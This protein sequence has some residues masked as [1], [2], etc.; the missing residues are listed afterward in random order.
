MKIRSK[1]LPYLLYILLATLISF[2]W[3]FPEHAI[4]DIVADQIRQVR[5][6]LTIHITRIRPVMPPGLKLSDVQVTTADGLPVDMDQVWLYPKWSSLLRFKPAVKFRMTLYEG[7]LNGVASRANRQMAVDADFAD[8]Q[9]KALPLVDLLP[10]DITIDP[11]QPGYI[12]GTVS[13]RSGPNN[14]PQAEARIQINDVRFEL[15]TDLIALEPIKISQMN[16]HLAL[17]TQRW[18]VKQCRFNGP[19]IDGRIN[20]T[21]LPR[22]P[23]N[24]SRLDLKAT[25]EPKADFLAQFSETFPIGLLGG[26]N[27]KFA[28][29]I[30]GNIDKPMLSL[31]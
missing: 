8:L 4:K 19:Q 12:T 24:Q 10:V 31:Q 25:L 1:S 17:D 20:G 23:F 16:T 28:F 27:A 11:L 22:H 18:Q 30:R 29:K 9:I 21:V 26:V 6:D 14:R 2:Y 13:A 5:P 7:R 15:S 3:L